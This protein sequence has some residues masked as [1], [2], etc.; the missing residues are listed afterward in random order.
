MEGGE[1]RGKV[2]RGIK[3]SCWKTAVRSGDGDGDDE[4]DVKMMAM[5]AMIIKTVYIYI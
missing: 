4:G 3:W 2:E 1:W 5:M